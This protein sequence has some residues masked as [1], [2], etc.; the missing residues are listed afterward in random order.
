MK[1]E[2][3]IEILE[4][5]NLGNLKSFHK[6]KREQYLQ[7]CF[8]VVTSKGK[9]FLKQYEK[10][11]FETAKKGFEIL[12][13]L[14]NKNYPSLN[15]L[16]T[17]DNKNYVIQNKTPTTIWEFMSEKE[18]KNISLQEAFELGKYLG[19]LHKITKDYPIPNANAYQRY[20]KM[21]RESY[22]FFP[23]APERVK[24]VLE[25]IKEKFKDLKVPT[26]QPEAVCHEEY[27]T[28]HVRFRNNKLVKVFDW[29]GAGRDYVFYDVGLTLNTA[30]KKNKINYS[31][32]KKI[33]QGYESQRRLTA[34]E[35][36]HLFECILFGAIKYF[37]WGNGKEEIK[38]D[39]W[40][41]ETIKGI[42]VL[43]KEEKRFYKKI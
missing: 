9:F 42:E 41:W 24:K 20:Y 15:L 25:Y 2:N 10:S 4:N 32:L 35:R 33:I 19:L 7:P 13:F 16:R 1:K 17:I 28:Q 36:K 29:D 12:H 8:I 5:Y 43:I 38:R 14:E 26:N 27:F 11:K 21:F 40:N 34:W 30:K 37:C 31:I 23:K 22:S 6:I 18:K 3:I 39:G